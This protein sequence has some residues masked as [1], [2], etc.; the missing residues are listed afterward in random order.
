MIQFFFPSL[1]AD[2]VTLDLLRQH[3]LAPLLSDCLSSPATFQ[4]TVSVINVARGPS[5]SSGTM[6]CPL[7]IGGATAKL[8]WHPD[9]QQAV[10]TGSYWLV[11]D[12]LVPLTPDSL[13]R[14]TLI[15][16]Y[17]IELRP[18]EAWL[19]PTLR[20]PSGATNLPQA[21]GLDAAGDFAT[22]VL[23][24]FAADWE[25]AGRIWDA[26]IGRSELS[27]SDAWTICCRL[28]Q[29][30]YRVDPR[31]I[32][33]LGL[34]T[35]DNYVDVLQAAVDGP[36]VKELLEDDAKKKSVDPSPPAPSNVSPGPATG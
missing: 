32:S 19:C 3:S 4:R 26:V 1:T 13:R 22:R 35:S 5:S 11:R 33:D 2:Q 36:L 17:E 23:P 24:Q 34:L 14:P 29:L 12:T 6:L 21:W 16:G 18:G 31:I 15:P 20:R 25:L 10:D 8:G 9:R 7:P 27:Q 28:L 30:N